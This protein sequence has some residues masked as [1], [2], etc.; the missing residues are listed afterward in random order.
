M[1][2]PARLFV[3]IDDRNKS[4]EKMIRKFLRMCKKERI[5]EIYKEKTTA[6]K[7]RTQKKREKHERAVRRIKREEQKK[8]VQKKLF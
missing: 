8:K 1:A 6:Y 7:T 4:Q 3:K 5:T 2:R